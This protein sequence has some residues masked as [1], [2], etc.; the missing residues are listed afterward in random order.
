[1]HEAGAAGPGAQ[2]VRAADLVVDGFVGIG[3][4][5][6]LPAPVAALTAEAD[7]CGAWRLAVDLPSGVDADTGR[8]PGAAFTA[9]VTVTF[10]A[11]KPGLLVDPGHRQAGVLELVDI[12]LGPWLGGR[13]AVVEAVEAADL[14]DPVAGWPR[15]AP[16]DDK[17]TRGVVGVVAGSAAYTGAAVLCV[18]AALKSGAGMVRFVGGPEASAAVRARWPE[19]VLGAGRV[20]AW[21]VGPGLGT[22]PDAADRVREALASDVPVLVDADGLT[23]LA[24]HPEWARERAARAPSALTVLTPHDREYERFGS[25]VGD[26]R[27]AA[28]RRLAEDLGATVLLKGS[29]TVVASAAGPARVNL[30]GTSWLATAGT[31]DVLAGVTGTL[32]AAGRGELAPAYAAF[33]HGLAGQLAADGAPLTAMEVVATLPSA[34][35]TVL[36]P[37]RGAPGGGPG[38][39]RIE[40]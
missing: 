8:V 18:G 35:A 36:E 37:A 34:L 21:V 11:L 31:G 3:G 30:T 10:G 29:T 39:G 23:A 9:D 1:V 19:A 24:Q 20:Q 40:R 4:R 16:S 38:R 25:P 13:S 17:Y 2:L 12:G 33:V 14:A 28:A 6:E 27:V 32:L 26:D 15:P 5:G 7:A 22:E